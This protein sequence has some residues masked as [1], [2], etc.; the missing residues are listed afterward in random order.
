MNYRSCMSPITF[1]LS[2][3]CGFTCIT[4]AGRFWCIVIKCDSCFP[5]YALK[6]RMTHPA[7]F[8]WLCQVCQAVSANSFCHHQST[9]YQAKLS[10]LP[11]CL[12]TLFPP[13]FSH[14]IIALFKRQDVVLMNSQKQ[15][16]DPWIFPP[17]CVLFYSPSY[18][19]S[20]QLVNV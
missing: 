17:L 20:H 15:T 2:L 13:L 9:A 14:S 18:L 19:F 4:S 6:K 12:Q 8:V 16:W 1:Y 10:I 7:W 11:H 5:K 3:P